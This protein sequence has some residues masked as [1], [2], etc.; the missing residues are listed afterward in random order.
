MQEVNKFLFRVRE[1]EVDALGGVTLCLQSKSLEAVAIHPRLGQVRVIQR[2][3][4]SLEE[5]PRCEL[6]DEDWFVLKNVD[7]KLFIVERFKVIVTARSK[8]CGNS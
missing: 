8:I 6:A 2:V 4:G 3:F 7:L 5:V 1:H